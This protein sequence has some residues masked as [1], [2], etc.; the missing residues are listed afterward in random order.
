M[1]VVLFCGGQGLRLRDYSETIPKPMIQIGYRPILW[2]VMKYYAHYGHRDFILALGYK[3]DMVKDYFLRYNECI[4]NDFVLSE[5]GKRIELLGSDFQNWK[6]TFVDTGLTANIGQRLLAVRPFLAGDP[7]FMASYA[8]GL[9][10][11]VL[12]EYLDAYFASGRIAGF[13]S[14]KPVNLTFHSV[15]A[16]AQNVVRSI[17]NFR[18]TGTR[19]NGGYFAFREEIFDY[20][21][22]G[23]ELVEQPFQRLIED[24]ALWVYPYDGFWAAM[25]TFKDKQMLDDMESRGEAPWEAWRTFQRHDGNPPVLRQSVGG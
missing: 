11:V 16:D 14:V 20:I 23:E 5:G 24:R 22:P 2:H 3:A 9:T 13:L 21:R 17:R 15:T 1:K 8:D 25:D 4:S 10:D 7:V 18:E 19:V 6:V 12:P